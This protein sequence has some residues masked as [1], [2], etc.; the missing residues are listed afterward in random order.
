MSHTTRQTIVRNLVL[1]I[2]MVGGTLMSMFPH[3]VASTDAEASPPRTWKT[4]AE[5]SPEERANID[6]SSETP[7]HSE[8]PYLPAEPFPFAPPYTAEEMGLRSMEFSYW[9]K[10][11]SSTVQAY[12]SIDAHGY[13]PSW[14]RC[15]TS[16]AYHVTDG[17]AGHLYAKPGQHDYSALL[18]YLAP[19]EA[20]GNQSLYIR[21]RT[22]QTFTK[23]QDT[24][25]YSSGLRRVRRYPAP[26][27]QDR[28]P[29]NSFTYDDDVGRDAWEYNWKLLGTDVLFHA[30]RF[31]VTRSTITLANVDG[32]FS[33]V[34]ANAIKL[35][36]DAYPWYT[37]EGGV[38]CYVVEATAKPDWLPDYYAPRILY[39]LDQHTF[40]PLRIEQYGKDG[41]L[42][43]IS[44]RLGALFNP[45]LGER[46]YSSVSHVDWNLSADV[47][48]YMFTDVT[49]TQPWSEADQAL[50][51]MP[52]F[53]PREWRLTSL[54]TQ[55]DVP[56]PQEFFL[57]PALEEDKFPGERR[58]ELSPE[59]RARVQA[60]EQAGR[61]VFVGE[62]RSVPLTSATIEAKA[63]PRGEAVDAANPAQGVRIE[64]THVSNSSH[65]LG[66]SENQRNL[67]KGE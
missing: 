14:G 37:P 54:K 11:T 38:K 51:F 50:F 27:R 57:R 58:I 5:L 18:Q 31:P 45:A 21:Y 49:L 20:Y 17:I 13:M 59:L 60:Q 29:A 55:A 26:P 47:L 25:R 8:F 34:P 32:S 65:F 2:L 16:I 67:T 10:W 61:L 9:R 41:T 53:M 30:V 15:V 28:Y 44:V 66:S 48:S 24:F 56:T 64:Q 39:W 6:F 46:G 23:K 43:F 40:F 3:V 42:I 52:G 4:V 63:I 12:G 7:R 19:P 36:G 35:M 22:D 33:D 62:A 1:V